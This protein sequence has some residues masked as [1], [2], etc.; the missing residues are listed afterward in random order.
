MVATNAAIVLLL[1]FIIVMC[2]DLRPAS[3]VRPAAAA[4]L[5][6]PSDFSGLTYPPHIC[7]APL[8]STLATNGNDFLASKG[9]FYAD[10]GDVASNGHLCSFPLDSVFSIRPYALGNNVYRNLLDSQ[11]AGTIGPLDG[12]DRPLTF[13]NVHIASLSIPQVE[14]QII[15]SF[16]FLGGAN[17]PPF[18][19][20]YIPISIRVEKCVLSC[21]SASGASGANSGVVNFAAGLPLGS[22][23]YIFN[24]TFSCTL[25]S[26]SFQR[27]IIFF[28]RKLT[29]TGVAVVVSEN[30]ISFRSAMDSVLRSNGQDVS[31][32]DYTLLLFVGNTVD[33][34][35]A[36]AYD[37]YGAGVWSLTSLATWA[38]RNHSFFNASFNSVKLDIKATARV[39]RMSVFAVGREGP[40]TTSPITGASG[41]VWAFNS[42]S[43]TGVDGS[44][45]LHAEV[46]AISGVSLAGHTRL[47]SS[48]FIAIE[49]NTQTIGMRYFAN[50]NIRTTA[51]VLV[52]LFAN[53]DKGLIFDGERIGDFD[54]AADG[55]GSSF[56]RVCGEASGR[57]PRRR[58]S[59][60]RIVNNTARLTVY[61]GY[62]LL[63]LVDATVTS[64]SLEAP[65]MDAV[66][67]PPPPTPAAAVAAGLASNV[68]FAYRESR[69]ANSRRH[70]HFGDG[71]DR[72][73]CGGVGDAADAPA[74]N[75]ETVTAASYVYPLRAQLIV[76]ENRFTANYA[77]REAGQMKP[78]HP[79]S[80]SLWSSAAS[81]SGTALKL[82]E[83]GTAVFAFNTA[84]ITQTR[85]TEPMIEREHGIDLGA[86]SVES[87]T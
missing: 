61:G 8:P 77:T 58:P 37:S 1:A 85:D 26:S 18:M 3:N 72:F 16:N 81:S 43:I 67:P 7:T 22:E 12:P 35:V 4:G 11:A 19:T 5:P 46:V 45:D 40:E 27:A 30:K 25:E 51:F 73:A 13:A 10:G 71:S 44:D 36:G 47:S 39:S 52:N 54:F 60:I 76:A 48:S 62:S 17:S 78:W 75:E 57:Q 15:A 6:S 33:V 59:H 24:N 21:T 63:R 14:F 20:D 84:T 87:R 80:G 41:I 65:L 42:V 66:P 79:S 74:I 50:T 53:N 28:S 69:L 32:V 38:F 70:Y 29:I 31:F 23:V 64:I 82:I 86:V 9:G 49:S 2:T 83:G 55:E 34:S 68:T 56:T